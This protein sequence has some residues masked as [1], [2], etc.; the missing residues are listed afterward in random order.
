[1]VANSKLMDST[2]MVD[3]LEVA[4]APEIRLRAALLQ[5]TMPPQSVRVLKPDTEPDGGY[6]S[7]KRVR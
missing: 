1:M 3:L 7:Y 5:L 4:P 6:T 2:R